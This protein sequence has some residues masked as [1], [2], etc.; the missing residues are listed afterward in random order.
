MQENTLGQTSIIRK[1]FV[2]HLE[3]L[4]KC[5]GEM[6]ITAENYFMIAKAHFSI[7]ALENRIRV[8]R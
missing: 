5:S 2:K 7:M 4:S 8:N 1:T 6:H 3:C